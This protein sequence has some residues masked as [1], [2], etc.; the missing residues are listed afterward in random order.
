MKFYQTF[1][2]NY[3]EEERIKVYYWVNGIKKYIIFK[4][5]TT[6]YIGLNIEY[7]SQLNTVDQ[8]EFLIFVSIQT[9]MI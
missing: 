7:Y 4:K 2:R 3:W 8:F 1:A 5:F 6:I 9:R